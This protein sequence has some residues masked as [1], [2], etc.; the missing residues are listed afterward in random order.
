MKIVKRVFS[1]LLILFAF[2]ARETQ[3]AVG[4]AGKY[5]TLLGVDK[6]ADE[7]QIKKQYRKLAMKHHP[8]KNPDKKEVIV[9]DMYLAKLCIFYLIVFLL[10]AISIIYIFS[11][12]QESEKKFKEINEAYETLSDKRKR[13]IYDLY[14]EDAAKGVGQ[15]KG[16]RL[17]TITRLIDSMKVL[18]DRSST[19]SEKLVSHLR[20][21][22]EAG[23]EDMVETFREEAVLTGFLVVLVH[24]DRVS[25][26]GDKGMVIL[27]R[28]ETWAT[29]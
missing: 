5:Y 8:D 28:W 12:S 22:V 2:T 6:N 18:V 15:V 25:V 4:S 14:G 3:S 7:T 24:L 27:R 26:L 21:M 17:V 16:S 29:S 9:I 10:S 19:Y 11:S 23:L 1:L 13:E 20:I